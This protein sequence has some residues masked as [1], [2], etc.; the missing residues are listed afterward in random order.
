MSAP[1]VRIS[2][3]EEL[4]KLVGERLDTGAEDLTVQSSL[5]DFRLSRAEMWKI[6]KHLYRQKR[7]A[8][9]TTA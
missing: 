3:E 7:A 6:R 2:T 8:N 4:L 1:V 5:G 9:E